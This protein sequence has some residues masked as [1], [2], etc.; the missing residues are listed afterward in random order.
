MA[1]RKAA[2]PAPSRLLAALPGDEVAL[3]RRAGEIA[4]A[5][6]MP[7][8][9]V[10]GPVRDLLLGRPSADVDL[11]VEGEALVLA[12]ALAEAL[13]GAVRATHSRFGTV[14]L[15]LP[16]REVDIAT[17]RTETYPRPGALPVVSTASARDDLCRRDFS[18]NAM[19][20]S[21]LPDSF[22]RLL[23]PCGGWP[24]LQRRRLRVMHDRSFH[25]DP[26]RLIR[27][28]RLQCRLDFT[29]EPHTEGLAREALRAG[30]LH[31]LTR[32]RLQQE[33]RL[34][35]Q[36]PAMPCQVRQGLRLG[37]LP[38]LIPGIA[39]E[40]LAAR[41]ACGRRLAAWAADHPHVPDAG[42]IAGLLLVAAAPPGHALAAGHRLLPGRRAERSLPALTVDREAHLAA[43]AAAR[44]PS[45]WARV[46][47]PLPEEAVLV[48]A[49]YLP[50]AARR[51]ARRY[52]ARWRHLRARLT[53]RDLLEMGYTPS[54]RWQEVFTTLRE[55]RMDGVTRSR[56][57]E[58]RLAGELLG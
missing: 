54:P 12:T 6:A 37:L 31:T 51:L 46:L 20:L 39:P 9:L 13:G 4:G 26:L 15:R 11:M 50:S 35:L 40:G 23:D 57:D 8:Y 56:E 28:V 22:G 36:E 43:L 1:G 52:L 3:L 30:A 7:I 2:P 19:A 49:C 53:G 32:R 16:A 45:D 44:R 58:E 14:K 48:L 27:A 38:A 5:L 34:F 18:I 10:G 42:L 24:D 29:L 47:D 25:D 55:A 33:F 21:L 41:M 17:A